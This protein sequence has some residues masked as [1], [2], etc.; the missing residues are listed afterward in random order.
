MERYSWP[1]LCY[2]LWDL[3][4]IV[5]LCISHQVCLWQQCVIITLLVRI[6]WCTKPTPLSWPYCTSEFYMA[7]R[8][9]SNTGVWGMTPIFKKNLCFSLAIRLYF[10]T[11]RS[12]VQRICHEGVRHL[13]WRS[14]SS[15]S[16]LGEFIGFILDLITKKEVYI[17][18]CTTTSKWRYCLPYHLA[19]TYEYLFQITKII[20]VQ[21]NKRILF[22]EGWQLEN[23]RFW[24]C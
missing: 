5:I 21:A 7:R 3:P 12:I 6:C 19:N 14:N 22:A 10:L 16:S 4:V 13:S 23:D 17:L 15:S 11:K 18:H 20:A 9:N 2:R 1:G 8:W 24:L